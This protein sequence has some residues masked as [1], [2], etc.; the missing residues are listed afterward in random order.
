MAEE[1]NDDVNDVG[2][3]FTNH[4]LEEEWDE[5][6]GASLDL[7]PP[8]ATGDDEEDDDDDDL[9]S[10]WSSDWDHEMDLDNEEFLDADD[11]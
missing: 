7:G 2:G 9:I 11:E 10:V 4:N 8:D 6:E 5:A 3:L 1:G